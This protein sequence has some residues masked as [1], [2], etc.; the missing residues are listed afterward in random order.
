MKPL[1]S[2]QEMAEIDRSAQEDYG[3]PQLVL[4]ENAGIAA[5]HRFCSWYSSKAFPAEK[6]STSSSW[7]FLAGGG[8]NG[9][10]A[11][12]M[13]RHAFLEGRSVKIVILKS[14]YS[15]AAGTQLDICRN[16]N[17]PEYVWEEDSSAVK[18]C[19]LRAAVLF[20]G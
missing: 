15:G 18:D 5:Y 9:G 3:I 10:D 14:S 20:D 11:L 8:N 4:M 6:N 12:V 2:A 7:V 13:A 1:A 17:I 16:L 19:M